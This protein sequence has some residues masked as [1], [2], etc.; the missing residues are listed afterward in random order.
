MI[1]IPDRVNLE[2]TYFERRASFQTQTL[3]YFVDVEVV[4]V[5]SDAGTV[6]AAGTDSL[7]PLRER[8]L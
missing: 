4:A 7:H 5:A 2:R 6:V 8:H 3:A 1:T